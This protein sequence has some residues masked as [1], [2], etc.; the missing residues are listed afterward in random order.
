[1]SDN[2]YAGTCVDCGKALR[3]GEGRIM[4]QA[5]KGS[6]RKKLILR[7]PRKARCHRLPTPNHPNPLR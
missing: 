7:C 2:K 3:A 1:M 4:R 5:G 6:N